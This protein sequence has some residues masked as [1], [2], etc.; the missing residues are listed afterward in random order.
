MHLLIQGLV[1]ILKLALIILI[2]LKYGDGFFYQKNL[3][4]KILRRGQDKIF[5]RR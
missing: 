4:K 5:K 1:S 2:N 3:I